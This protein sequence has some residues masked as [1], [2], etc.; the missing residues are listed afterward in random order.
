MTNKSSVRR[1]S[2]QRIPLPL[3]LVLLGYVV[4]NL[5]PFA[6]MVATSF[7]TKKDSFVS[8]GLIPH[9]FSTEAW[10]SVWE[11]MNVPSALAN[12]VIYAGVTVVAVLIIYPMAGFVFA[13]ARFRGKNVL[14]GALLASLL[15]PSI[16]LLV[17]IVILAQETGLVNNWFGILLPTISAA[18]PIPLYLTR[19]YFALLPGELLDAA[20]VDGASLFMTYRRVFLPLSIPALTT[21]AILT[22][23]YVWNTYILPSLLITDEGKFTLP[24]R[25][26]G[27]DASGAP[28]RNELMAGAVIIIIPLIGAFLI[29]QRYYIAGLASGATKS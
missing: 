28:G 5:Y 23:V 4:L 13:H 7:K 22:L 24:L 29:L 12:S 9:P 21:S 2:N 1:R 14:F 8:D 17:P 26:F 11:Q 19:N 16:V 25:L 10:P 27:F 3:V 6:W 20:K 15:V 18:G